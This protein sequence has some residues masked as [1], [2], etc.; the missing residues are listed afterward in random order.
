[1]SQ[2]LGNAACGTRLGE[3]SR[4][5]PSADPQP[6]QS[7]LALAVLARSCARSNGTPLSCYVRWQDVAGRP[8]VRKGRPS[9]AERF[10]RHSAGHY[11]AAVR[12]RIGVNTT[13]VL[14]EFD[15]DRRILRLQA[16]LACRDEI[17]V[18]LQH[19]VRDLRHEVEN[20]RVEQSYAKCA[21]DLPPE[22][23]SDLR[24]GVTP[25]RSCAPRD[26]TEGLSSAPWNTRTQ[27]RV[28]R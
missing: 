19:V 24:V 28:S 25:Q 12:S 9:G 18:A 15:G 2:L 14:Y 11:P 7:Q 10:S 21:L 23:Q 1:M 4:M 17:I 13:A 22:E 8:L 5:T 16:E 26:A 6:D 3:C 20:L 27:G